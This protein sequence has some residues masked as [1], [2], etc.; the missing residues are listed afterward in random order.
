MYLLHKIKNNEAM[1][2][3]FK[4]YLSSFY[5]GICPYHSNYEIEMI[6]STKYTE[7]E[8]QTFKIKL[9]LYFVFKLSLAKVF[10]VTNACLE[11]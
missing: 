4:T 6:P 1:A 7:I 9:I 8:Y 5:F 11:Q 10:L 3:P 2:A